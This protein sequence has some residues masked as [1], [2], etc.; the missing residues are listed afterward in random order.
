MLLI[1]VSFFILMYF[2]LHSLGET[3]DYRKN[4]VIVAAITMIF[5]SGLRHE[6]VGNDTFVTMMKFDYYSE[7]P[8][9]YILED[10]WEKYSNP[11]SD[12]G[13]DPGEEIFDKLISYI[14]PDSRGFLIAI[15]FFVITS[16]SIFIYKHARTLHSVM[17]TY[18]FYA[19]MFYP[20]IPNS[21]AR[22]SLALGIVLFA[23]TLLMKKKRIEFIILLL[24]ASTLHKSSLIA[25]IMLPLSYFNKVRLVY[26]GAIPAF[27]FM[28]F[29]YNEAA[30]ILGA[31]N[32]I[33]E[34]YILNNYYETRGKARPFMVIVLIAGLYLYNII[35]MERDPNREYNKY[36]YYGTA[37]TL[38]FTPLI[39]FDPS[40]IRLASY[41]GLYLGMCIGN[42]SNITTI[43]RNGFIPI[44]AIFYLRVASQPD[45]GYRFMWQEKESER[46][47]SKTTLLP[48][49]HSKARDVS[50]TY[51]W[52][53]AS[54]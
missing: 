25:G 4:F 50:L 13:K 18:I 39:L 16:I 12:T 24:L 46:H 36:Y 15:A 11:N 32:D 40:A 2:F 8:W 23:Y 33:Y 47:K 43:T 48:T 49:E 35:I 42:L 34:G 54:A 3:L 28:C 31:A 51:T 45:D 26:Y 27:L 52:P 9:R 6:Y 53:V 17:F 10:F 7:T 21:A 44:I 5:L 20:Y 30:E 14:V 22:Q 1:L 19:M 41:F 37:L 38:V 29:F